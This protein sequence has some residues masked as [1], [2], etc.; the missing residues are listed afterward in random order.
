MKPLFNQIRKS[1]YI[2]IFNFLPYPAVDFVF[3]RNILLRELIHFHGVERDD[4]YLYR[5]FKG[6]GYFQ[7]GLYK[8]NFKSIMNSIGKS[9]PPFMPDI[10]IHVIVFEKDGALTKEACSFCGTLYPNIAFSSLP[11]KHFG[12]HSHAHLLNPIIRRFIE[13]K[14]IVGTSALANA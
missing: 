2:Y 5:D 6:D 10:P 1:W 8:E 4:P 12:L 14:V 7:I 11:I 3:N 9:E 13:K